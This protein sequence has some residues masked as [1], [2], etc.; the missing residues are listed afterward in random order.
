MSG[1][2]AAFAATSADTALKNRGKRY[3]QFVADGVISQTT[4]DAVNEY[5]KT[6]RTSKI[7]AKADSTE[8]KENGGK[9][10]GMEDRW[11]TV[12]EAG[13]ITQAEYD[14]IIAALPQKPSEDKTG[15]G[16]RAKPENAND[17]ARTKAEDQL[18]SAGIITQSEYEA[19][20]AAIE[21]VRA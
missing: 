3:E 14:A 12:L 7:A 16:M 19:M 8:A 13:V 2:I 11:K 1:G 10:E 20:M 21:A 18:L 17:T 9:L 15:D 5:R 4:A 6:L